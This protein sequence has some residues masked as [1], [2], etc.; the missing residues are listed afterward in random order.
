MPDYAKT[1][2]AQIIR[3]ARDLI[4]RMAFH[5]GRGSGCRHPG[6]IALQP[7]QRPCQP[8]VLLQQS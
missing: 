1:S 6:S 3:A 4:E 8:E 2:E 5:N 7:V